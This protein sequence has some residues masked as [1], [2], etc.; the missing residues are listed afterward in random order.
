MVQPVGKVQPVKSPPRYLVGLKFALGSTVSRQQHDS[1]DIAKDTWTVV[2]AARLE[3]FAISA[4]IVDLAT[5]GGLTWTASVVVSIYLFCQ[6]FLSN[7]RF[8]VTF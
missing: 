5:D 3:S 4:Y 1:G 8:F 7:H 2:K 6:Y